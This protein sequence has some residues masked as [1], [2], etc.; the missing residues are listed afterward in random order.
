MFMHRL[1]CLHSCLIPTSPI[2][3]RMSCSCRRC[4]LVHV[5]KM[6]WIGNHVQSKC[7]IDVC[8]ECVNASP[9]PGLFL[10]FIELL[11]RGDKLSFSPQLRLRSNFRSRTPAARRALSS[12]QIAAFERRRK[13]TSLY[14]VQRPTPPN[15][16]SCTVCRESVALAAN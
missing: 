10:I 5:F 11:A 1:P 16:W 13:S 9:S 2:T 14:V 12:N 7:S 6:S 8:L 3:T 4:S 15:S